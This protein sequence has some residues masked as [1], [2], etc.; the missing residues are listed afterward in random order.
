[1]KK[2]DY[3]WGFILILA[4]I[5][6]IVNK[7]GFFGGISIFEIVLTILLVGIIIKN[8][9]YVN[10]GGILFPIAFLCIIYAQEL[11]IENLT[12]FPVLLTALLGSIGLSMIFKP[13]Q[14]WHHGWEHGFHR[15]SKREHFDEV[16]DQ[17]DDNVVNCSV[18]FGSSM[19]YI[20]TEHFEKANIR[21]SF[22]AMKVYFDNAII[23]TDHAEIY[24]DVSFGGVEL[25]IPR[26][27]NLVNEVNTS[28]AGME[29]KNRKS[30]SISPVV[31]MR[32]N[33]SFS[34]VEI[35]YV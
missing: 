31:V 34:G 21:C 5:L 3:F 23:D 10:F 26:G 27:W 20:N 28:L 33:I 30:D 12:P 14:R 25:F 15:Y 18:S 8:I 17:P 4:A 2:R 11:H 24:L 6:V 35:I 7:L 22:G 9:T 32:G 19:K 16:I 1:M 13:N 29:E